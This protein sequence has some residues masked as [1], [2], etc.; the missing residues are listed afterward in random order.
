M[1]NGRHMSVELIEHKCFSLD[2]LHIFKNIFYFL[3]IGLGAG[4][5]NMQAKRTQTSF[6]KETLNSFTI[7][8]ILECSNEVFKR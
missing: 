6:R 5:Q 1:E 7:P 4:L 3:H 8:S 2:T